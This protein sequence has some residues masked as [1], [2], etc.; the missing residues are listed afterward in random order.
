MQ[1]T[2]TEYTG[3]LIVALFINPSRVKA[4]AQLCQ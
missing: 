3:F 4:L 2:P 1:G